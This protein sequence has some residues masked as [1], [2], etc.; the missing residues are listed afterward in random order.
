MSGSQKYHYSTQNKKLHQILY[1]KL[2]F[3]IFSKKNCSSHFVF[4][5]YKKFESRFFQLFFC[6]SQT[7]KHLYSEYL[8]LS[9]NII[10]KSLFIKHIHLTLNF[11]FTLPIYENFPQRQI[12]V[13]DKLTE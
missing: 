10:T 6:Q 12:L 2:Y 9:L 1:I 3:Q 4:I 7:V 11:N 13:A 8:R 5:L